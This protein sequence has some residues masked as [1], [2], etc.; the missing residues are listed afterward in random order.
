MITTFYAVLLGTSILF[1]IIYA[2]IWHKHFDIN[3]SLLFA[4]IPLVCAGYV[5][6]DNSQ[7]LA[8]ALMAKKILYMAIFLS[9]FS[10]LIVLDKCD[11]K[12]SKAYRLITLSLTIIMYLG[13][14]S[15]GYYPFFYKSVTFEK[16]N[17]VTVLHPTY[18]WMHTFTYFLV[19]YY[20]VLS[21]LCIVYSFFFKKTISRK[22]CALLFFPVSCSVI[23]FF[24]GR[25]FT[26]YLDFSP[27]SYVFAQIFYLLIVYEMCLYEVNDTHIDS[28]VREGTSGF[29]SF[30][31]SVRYL[32]SNKAAQN[33]I[34]ELKTINID[35]RLAKNE[36]LNEILGPWINAFK[37]KKVKQSFF[38]ERDSKIYAIDVDYLYDGLRKRGYRI[39]INDDTINQK[40]IALVDN[41][42]TQLRDKVKEKTEKIIETNNNLLLSMATMIESRDNSTG[43]HIKRSSENVRILVNEIK[44][45][46]NGPL[47]IDQIFCNY[48][49]K[50]APM[51]DLGKIAVKD[52]ILQKPGKFEPW[53]YDEMKKHAAEG[54]KIVH[55]VLETND[56]KVFKDIAEN[57]AHYHHERWD[58]SGYPEGLKGKEIPLEARIMAIADVYDALVSKRVYKESMSFEE[59]DKIIMDGFGTQFDEMLKEYYVAARPK[60]E[61]YY[62]SLL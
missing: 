44:S 18:G 57:V 53:E 62:R 9:Y 15:I 1:T 35:S 39:F 5:L 6:F 55:E 46:N 32:G 40:H 28:L 24:A 10:M 14:L 25:L 47:K 20:Y 54:A 31:Y 41:F 48:V 17:G 27:F 58:G 4:F 2:V 21:L 33:Y 12:V 16:I 50:A 3:L 52:S 13:V 23:S 61:E 11:I 45:D 49:I 38:Y 7:T 19:V 22:I 30:D 59:A 34:P 37:E 26:N 51:H 56:D 29:I 42:N 8:E 60:L 43:G 36:K